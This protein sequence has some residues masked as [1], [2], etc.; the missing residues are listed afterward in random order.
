MFVGL[1]GGRMWAESSG[2][3]GEGT[4]VYFSIPLPASNTAM[5]LPQ[6][7][8][9][10][11]FWQSRYDQARSE[12]NIL[13]ASDETT[14]LRMA[15]RLF[16]NQGKVVR[17]ALGTLL[18]AVNENSPD[19][20]LAFTKHDQPYTTVMN[21]ISD[22]AGDIPVISCRLEHDIEVEEHQSLSMEDINAWLLKPV[23][24][25]DLAAT[26]RGIAPNA[27]LILSV[28]D[29]LSMARFYDVSVVGDR[30]YLSV[31]TIVNVTLVSEVIPKMEER[32]PDVILLDLNLTDG[33]GWDVLEMIRARWTK[34]Q[35]PVIIITA[36]D[37]Y[38]L[39]ALRAGEIKISNARGFSQRQTVMCLQNVLD[40][41]LG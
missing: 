2:I 11:D 14:V 25:E 37:R 30:H 13:V 40:A 28:E 20:I 35:V 15:S 5:E 33:S 22:N 19:V 12:R 38:G 9:D 4:A 8:R 36:M 29:D 34:E 26:I 3:D 27:K 24:R 21:Q 10:V 31:P 16:G 39:P 18:S 23:S 1:H 41:V 6:S 32:L 17:T 7:Q